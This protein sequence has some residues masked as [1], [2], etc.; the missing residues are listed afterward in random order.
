MLQVEDRLFK[1]GGTTYE[2]VMLITLRRRVFIRFVSSS[3]Q[4]VGALYC[5]FSCFA[6]CIVSNNNDFS[7][8]INYQQWQPRGTSYTLLATRLAIA[9]T[10]PMPCGALYAFPICIGFL[11]IGG[12]DVYYYRLGSL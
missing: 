1:S 2:E 9:T 10:Y 12:E 7:T 4:V 11:C 6:S 8:I 3:T 5:V